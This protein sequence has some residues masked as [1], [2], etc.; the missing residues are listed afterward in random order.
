MLTAVTEALAEIVVKLIPSFQSV[1]PRACGPCVKAS[2][3]RM[4]V[5]LGFHKLLNSH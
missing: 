1:Y 5:S 4:H 3:T 2:E